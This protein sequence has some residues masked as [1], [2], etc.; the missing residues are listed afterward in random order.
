M[1]PVLIFVYNAD[2]GVFNGLTDL[3]HKILSPETYQCNLCAVTYSFT[4]MKKDWKAFLEKLEWPVE[5]L[6]RDQLETQYDIS[7]VTL[8]AI[9]KKSGEKLD[10]WLDADAIN[11]CKTLQDLQQL[12]V[13]E[14]KIVG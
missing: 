13:E 10:V 11:R 7:D 3:A 4:G 8:P 14:V 6:H 12:I 5:F 1:K 9:F 2:A